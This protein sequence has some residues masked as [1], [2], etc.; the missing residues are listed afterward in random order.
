MVSGHLLSFFKSQE[1]GRAHVSVMSSKYKT[2]REMNSCTKKCSHIFFCAPVFKKWSN[3]DEMHV[4]VLG[5]VQCIIIKVYGIYSIHKGKVS[6][7]TLYLISFC[8]VIN[9]VVNYT[10]SGGIIRQCSELY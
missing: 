5:I 7:C 8:Y 4:F 9:A 6:T 1:L 10:C 2:L 3:T